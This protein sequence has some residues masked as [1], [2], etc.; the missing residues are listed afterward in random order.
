MRDRQR[1]SLHLTQI[2]ADRLH[3]P[4]PFLPF[5]GADSTPEIESVAR[6]NGPILELERRRMGCLANIR[7]QIDAPG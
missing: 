1:G 6:V 2:G 5:G 3:R 7:G 4:S